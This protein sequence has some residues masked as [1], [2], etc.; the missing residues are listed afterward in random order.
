[1][2]KAIITGPTGAVGISL[3]NELIANDYFVTAICRPNSK[4]IHNI[5]AHKNI[6]ILE[7]DQA[8]LLDL[9]DVLLHD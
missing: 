1:M 4:R 2:K 7:C 6:E 3:I 5:P 8:N 9:S